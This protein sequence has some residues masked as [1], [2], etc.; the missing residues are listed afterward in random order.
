MSAPNQLC[1]Y[2]RY[3]LL[4]LVHYTRHE[5]KMQSKNI[6]CFRGCHKR[7]LRWKCVAPVCFNVLIEFLRWSSD[8]V[9]DSSTAYAL[10]NLGWITFHKSVFVKTIQHHPPFSHISWFGGPFLTSAIY[11]NDRLYLYSQPMH[12]EQRF[13]IGPYTRSWG[14]I[15]MPYLVCQSDSI[16]QS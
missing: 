2:H 13:T 3:L 5:E 6:D 9:A 14:T 12:P 10:A 8:L 11:L 16:W 7:P 15:C 4:Q 1:T